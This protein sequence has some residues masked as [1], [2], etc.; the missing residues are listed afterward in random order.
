MEVGARL[1]V[2]STPVRLHLSLVPDWVG[3]PLYVFAQAVDQPTP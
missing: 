1:D 2:V 3:D